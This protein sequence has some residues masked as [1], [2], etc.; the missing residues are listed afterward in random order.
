[1]VAL[2]EVSL[3][4]TSN[5]PLNDSLGRVYLDVVRSGGRQG[6][7]H[8]EVEKTALKEHDASVSGPKVS[9]Y[10]PNERRWLHSSRKA[11]LRVQPPFHDGKANPTL[12]GC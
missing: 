1:M 5:G 4:T 2:I 11:H 7:G 12:P 6:F 3:L 8:D 9:I 10:P